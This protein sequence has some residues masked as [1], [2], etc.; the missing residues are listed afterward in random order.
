VGGP[1]LGHIR[2][3]APIATTATMMTV[4]ILRWK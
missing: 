1:S 4:R 2:R 3:M